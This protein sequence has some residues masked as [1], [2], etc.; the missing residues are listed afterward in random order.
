ML[1]TWLPL[2]AKKLALTSPTNGGRSVDI[3]RSRTV[4]TEFSLVLYRGNALDQATAAS[5]SYF[6]IY[7]LSSDHFT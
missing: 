2:S 4:A 6:S 5:F 3:V 7:S 1:T